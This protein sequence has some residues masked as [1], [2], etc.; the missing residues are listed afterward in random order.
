MSLKIY[1]DAPLLPGTHATNKNPAVQNVLT[2][3]VR[4]LAASSLATLTADRQIKPEK[5]Q[6]S[7]AF[8]DPNLS[9]TWL[10][11][12]STC[13]SSL[14]KDVKRRSSWLDLRVPARYNIGTSH[15]Q[16]TTCQCGAH[17]LPEDTDEP[18]GILG[19]VIKMGLVVCC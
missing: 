3:P 1:P 17:T 14:G 18:K 10:G 11:S 9:T 8:T 19:R 5:A 7:I 13:N 2:T 16:S 12:L 15:R 6:S 4:S